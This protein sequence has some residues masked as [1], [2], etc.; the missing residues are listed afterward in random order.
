[1]M[2]DIDT[3]FGANEDLDFTNLEIPKDTP[4]ERIVESREDGKVISIP[5]VGGLHPRYSRELRRAG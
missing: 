2:E 1:M 5:R 4:E 3:R